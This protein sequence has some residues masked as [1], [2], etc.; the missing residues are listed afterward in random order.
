MGKDKIAKKEAKAKIKI[1]K[2]Q[3]KTVLTDETLQNMVRDSG[4]LPDSVEM[5]IRKTGGHSELILTGLNDEQV[6][7]IIPQVAREIRI[8]VTEDQHTVK[9]GLMRFMREG[10][11]QTLIKVLAGLIVGYLLMRLGF[12]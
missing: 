4:R 3:D 11:F 5:H 2:A 10:L 7:R 6:G 9:A 8:A 12:R 1:A